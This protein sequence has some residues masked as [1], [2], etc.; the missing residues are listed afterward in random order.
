MAKKKDKKTDKVSL[1]LTEETNGLKDVKYTFRLA[2]EDGEIVL[3]VSKEGIEER[4]IYISEGGTMI[5]DNMELYDNIS[6]VFDKDVDCDCLG[7]D[8]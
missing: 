4:V 1:T 8:C 6:D 5:S 3:Y 7:W 2:K